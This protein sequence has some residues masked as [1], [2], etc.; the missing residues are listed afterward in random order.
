MSPSPPPPP[1]K[2]TV[3]FLS[4]WMFKSMNVKNPTPQK[5]TGSETHWPIGM[6][7]LFMRGGLERVLFT[8]GWSVCSKGEGLRGHGQGD[9]G[10]KGGEER[11]EKR[12][13]RKRQGEK[14]K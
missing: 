14:R 8:L 5:H 2:K 7:D 4:I 6:R 13:E 12:R 3:L 10:K 1:K 11:R 9:C